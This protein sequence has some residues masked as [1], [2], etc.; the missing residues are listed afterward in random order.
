MDTWN[1]RWI[2]QAGRGSR[3]RRCRKRP[4]PTWPGSIGP[5]AG[6][7][8]PIDAW[9]DGNF[10]TNLRAALSAFAASPD[11]GAVMLI[12]DTMD[13][14]ATRPTRYV[15]ALLQIASAA[16]KPFYMLSARA[17]LFRRDYADRLAAEGA[18]QLS[19]IEPALRAITNAATWARGEGPAVAPAHRGSRC[20]RRHRRRRY[21]AARGGGKALPRRARLCRATQPPGHRRG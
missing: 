12:T 11:Y 1:T 5:F 20:L 3:C 21:L 2:P 6:P 8:N 7:G 13:G 16:D 10:E 4:A 9:G 14:Q 15:D 18:C 17:G 19:G